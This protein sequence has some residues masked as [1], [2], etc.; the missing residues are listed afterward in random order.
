MPNSPLTI[1]LRHNPG[2]TAWSHGWAYLPPFSEDGDYLRW[3]VLLPKAGP[4]RLAIRWSE[5]T[6]IIRVAVPGKKIA[7]ADRDF[8]RSR[9][10]WMFR[11]DED[12]T[13][14]WGLCRGHAV[15]RQCKSL[16]TGALLRCPTVFEDV[17]KTLCTINAH[18]RNTKRMVENLCRMFG[19][20]CPGEGA[21]FTFPGPARLAGA[22]APDLQAAKLGFRARYIG[23]F[24]RRVAA[25]DLDLDAWR[26]EQDTATLR[27]TVLGVK[28]IGNYAANHLLML[29]GHYDQVPCDSEVRAYLG[30]SPKIPQK[31]VERIMAKRYGHWGRFA[32]LAYKFERVFAKENYVDC[33]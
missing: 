5:Q 28:G 3:A 2:F 4:R 19:E 22:S 6:D 27:A 15:L 30:L 10:R 1:H 11:A 12:F 8:I 16:R 7:A 29:L 31:E 24:A 26:Q 13:A 25:G 14:F 23:E 17:V 21:A 32:Y 20:A 9:V 33:E 18:W